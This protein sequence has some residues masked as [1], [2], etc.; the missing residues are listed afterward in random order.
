MHGAALLLIG[1]AAAG[2]T[3]YSRSLGSAKLDAPT[4]DA[5]GY[6]EKK[7]LKREER[8]LR[9]TLAPGEKE[10]GWKTPQALRIGGDFTIVANLVLG[11]IP[12]P[13]QEDGAAVGLAIA[14]QN[15]DQPNATLVRL[16]EPNGSDVYRSIEHAANNPAQPQMAMA[17]PMR[18][19]V[20]RPGMPRAAPAKPPRPTFPASGET[21]RLEI[22]REGN[23]I[24]YQVVDGKTDRP[25]YLGQAALGTNDVA[26]VKLFAANRN[27]AEALSV[28]LRDLTIRADRI[29]GLGT[30]VHTVFGEV[31]YADPTAIEKATLVVGGQPRTP[32]T[33]KQPAGSRPAPAARAA[34]TKPAE[35]KPAAPAETKPALPA[36]VEV[37]AVPAP[38]VVALPAPPGGAVGL[39]PGVVVIANVQP[40]PASAQPGA[41]P[42]AAAARSKQPRVKIP[43]DEVESIRFERT[44]ALTG[45]F[46]GQPEVDFTMPGLSARKDEP[47][48]QAE[49]RTKAA[50]TDDLLAPPPGTT[51]AAVTK[52]ARVE[53]KPNGIRDVHLALSGLR[54]VAIK[55]VTVNGQ[56]DKGST[57]WRLDTANS[58]DWP[59]VVRRAGTEP[60]AD[61]FL[62]PPPGDSHRKTYNVAVNYQ[63]GQTA[64]TAINVGDRHTDPKLAVGKDGPGSPPPDVWVY[65][66]GQEKLFGKLESLGEETLRLLTPW[67]DHVDVPLARVVGIHVGLSNRKESPE[68]FA[69]RLTSR[70]A[71]DLLLAQTKNGEVVA[72]PGIVEGTEGSRLRFL[73]QEKTRTLPLE[74]VEGLVMAARPE[75]K[76]VETLIST[77]SLSGGIVVS[78][79][80]KD[81]DT[82]VW[83]VET[84]WGP[85]LKLPAAEVQEVRFRGG[86]MTYLSDLPPSQVEETPFFGRRLSWRPDVNLLGDPLK[87]SGQTFERGLAVHSRC[88]LTYDLDG[89]YATF[90]TLLGFD[91]AAR[92]K[93]RVECRVLADG[94]ELYANPDLRADGPPVQLA[95]PVAGVEQLRL[96]VDFGRGQ[97]TG[98]RVIWANARLYRRPPPGLSMAPGG[99]SSPGP[100][101]S[102]P[103][104]G[105]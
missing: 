91:D 63:D 46:V 49:A 3:E 33:A 23:V 9:I 68:S 93:G 7:A 105:K 79:R 95:L 77:F 45:R 27:G 80:W 37:E 13:A 83:K 10:T 17:M 11:K 40:A 29:S 57:A 66:T 14:F 35:T 90:E 59:L 92:G 100:S 44:P 48:P 94:K 16:V 32:P 51:A 89:R 96:L 72:I 64:N 70:G 60:W 20:V 28:L 81:L 36:T 39:P 1:L 5:E 87:M 55:Q 104:S 52:V 8:G 26:G 102:K 98:D 47:A 19:A 76:A 58:Q 86:Q 54:K 38:P 73:Y 34:E 103:R 22:R 12:K 101:T 75:S 74:L 24:R 85:T 71:E 62:E 18:V 67:E 97:D 69:K 25:R 2:A 65:L 50:A 21:V 4:L 30:V 88:V 31:V 6:G 15:V 82:A 56:T 43:L 53:P 84:G 99:P 42:A 61:L 41:S 78:G